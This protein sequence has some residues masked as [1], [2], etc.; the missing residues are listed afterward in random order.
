M[1]GFA[2]WPD[3]VMHSVHHCICLSLALRAEKCHGFFSRPYKTLYLE[4]KQGQ[5]KCCHVQPWS[6][7]WFLTHREKRKAQIWV[8]SYLLLGPDLPRQGWSCIMFVVPSNPNHSMILL[9]VLLL[10]CNLTRVQL[11]TGGTFPARLF[12]KLKS[13]LQSL[14]PTQNYTLTILSGRIHFH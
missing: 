10:P 2:V 3:A 5:D 1:L 12:S 11:W 8:T 4:R 13:F 7:A 6:P 14:Y 9:W